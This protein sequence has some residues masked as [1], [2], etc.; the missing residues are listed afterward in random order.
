MQEEMKDISKT[1]VLDAKAEALINK[2]T[3][4]QTERAYRYKVNHSKVLKKPVP[5]PMIIFSFYI[6][7][8][9]LQ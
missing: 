5:I 1:L 7:E 4:L 9:A 3:P 2:W 8:A 6:D